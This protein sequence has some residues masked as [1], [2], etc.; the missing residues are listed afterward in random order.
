MEK[1]LQEYLND[2][3]DICREVKM[4]QVIKVGV[5]G[6]GK[7]LELAKQLTKHGLSWE[8]IEAIASF[9]MVKSNTVKLT[10][11]QYPYYVEDPEKVRSS[12]PGILVCNDCGY[13]DIVLIAGTVLGINFDQL[14][15]CPKCRSANVTILKNDS[16]KLRRNN[17]ITIISTSRWKPVDK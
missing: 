8:D 7:M 11:Q 15:V 12:P 1:N 5:R 6:Q 2:I 13:T 4:E 16:E 14:R 10:E 17:P 9:N 3:I